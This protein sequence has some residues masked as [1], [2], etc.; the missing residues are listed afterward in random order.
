MKTDEEADHDAL[1]NS[2]FKMHLMELLDILL[3]YRAKHDKPNAGQGVVKI[4]G[5]D[6][7]IEWLPKSEFEE[8]RAV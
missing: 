6:I 1:K 4:R 5:N 8:L 3:I 2:G 7:T